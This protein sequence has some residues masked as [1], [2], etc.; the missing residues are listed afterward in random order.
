MPLHNFET[1][2]ITVAEQSGAT[3]VEFTE[4]HLT[5]DDNVE[6]LGYELFTLSDK[7]RCLRMVLNMQRVSYL[8]SSA[9]GK[10]IS[11]HRKQHR[12][13]GRLVL[14]NI[15]AP[16]EEILQSSRLITYFNTA[17]DVDSAVKSF[18]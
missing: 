8:T 6:L 15:E 17:E 16:L 13:G 1:V 5:E 2:C 18:E 11:L 12:N 10:I 4:S 7:F 9:L 14:C 3:V